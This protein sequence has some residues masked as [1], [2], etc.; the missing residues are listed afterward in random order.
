MSSIN[1][2]NDDDNTKYTYKSSWHLS[3]V[4]MIESDSCLIVKVHDDTDKDGQKTSTMKTTTTM[5]KR[6]KMKKKKKKKKKEKEKEEEEE[7]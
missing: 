6:K 1:D 7:N 3:G 4:S 2:N 5:T